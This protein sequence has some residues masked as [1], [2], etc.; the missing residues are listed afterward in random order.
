[1]NMLYLDMIYEQLDELAKTN[2][3]AEELFK[4]FTEIIN[5]TEAIL[6]Q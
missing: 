6:K 3:E 4:E 5:K 1:M 2:E